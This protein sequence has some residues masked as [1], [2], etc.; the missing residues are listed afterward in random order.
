MGLSEA[1]AYESVRFSF[2][3]TNGVDDAYLAARTIAHA[4]EMNA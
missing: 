3:A 2:S 4:L 1:Q